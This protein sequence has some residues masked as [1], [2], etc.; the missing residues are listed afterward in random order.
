VPQGGFKI[1]EAILER[2]VGRS[3]VEPV[4]PDVHA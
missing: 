2:H 3:L 1:T 4:R